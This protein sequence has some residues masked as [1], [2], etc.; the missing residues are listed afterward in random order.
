MTGKDR[1]NDQ[2]S[3]NQENRKKVQA[4][5]GAQRSKALKKKQTRRHGYGKKDR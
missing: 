5:K 3:S 2:T 4:E 1:E